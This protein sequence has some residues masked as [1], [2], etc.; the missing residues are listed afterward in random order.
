VLILVFVSIICTICSNCTKIY[1]KT[2]GL[3]ISTLT[4]IISYLESILMGSTYNLAF[5][6]PNDGD[7][8]DAGESDNNNDNQD[9]NK[10]NG[11]NDDNNGHD[12]EPDNKKPEDEPENPESGSE[13]DNE[14]PDNESDNEND[15]VDPEDKSVTERSDDF[16][17]NERLLDDLDLLVQAVNG[18]SE[19]QK[20]IRENYSAFF[21]EESG[22]TNFKDGAKE[23]AHYLNEELASENRQTLDEVFRALDQ[24]EYSSPDNNNI[25][26][27][28][29]D[30]DSSSDSSSVS[31]NDSDNQFEPREQLPIREKNKRKAEDE[32]LQPEEVKKVKFKFNDDDDD[33]N[34]S[35]GAGGGLGPSGPSSSS[36][37]AGPSSSNNRNIELGFLDYLFIS[38]ASFLEIFSE[39]ISNLPLE[40]FTYLY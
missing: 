7:S 40:V 1:L 17:P 13:S 6:S 14:K 19:A 27:S 11:N 9:H 32:E 8:N 38:L 18:D 36:G 10:D 30:D 22:N 26:E 28:E 34:G 4:S 23:V 21:D 16:S 25:S 12:N 24:A 35:G 29:K 3:V 31:E 15:P 33:N 37:G 5:A 20:E 39:I 2:C